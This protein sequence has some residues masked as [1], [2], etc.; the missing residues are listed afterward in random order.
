MLYHLPGGYTCAGESDVVNI[1]TYHDGKREVVVAMGGSRLVT[2][3]P[4]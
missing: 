2:C 1:T 4:Q 3:L